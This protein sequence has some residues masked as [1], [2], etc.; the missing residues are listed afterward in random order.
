MAKGGAA[1]VFFDIVGTFQ[2]ERI[3]GD[4]RQAMV[5]KQAIIVD[6][7]GGI[8]DA[9]DE[10]FM[11]IMTATTTAVESFKLYED[12]LIRVRKFY[13]GS[14]EEIDAF[15][16]S[17]RNLGEQF[18]FTGAEALSA[19]ARTAQLKGVLKSQNAIIEATRAGLLLAAV[20]EME[21][22]LAMN[23]FINLAQQT[24]FLM[25]NMTRAQYDQLTAEQQANVIRG[26]SIR[27]LD[28]LNTIEN[29]SVAVME[30]ITFVLNQFA[31]QANIAGES[32]GEMA[33][34]SALLLETGEEVSRAGTGLRM[35]YQRVGNVNT[36]AAK[37]I[38]ALLDGVDEQGVAQMRLTDI[39]KE[40]TPAYQD[41]TAEQKRNLAVAV[42]GVRHYVK[43]LKLMENTERLTELQ[44]AAYHGQYGAIDEFG[45]RS[46]SMSFKIQATEARIENLRVAIGD[47]LAPAYE[48]GLQEQEAFFNSL[49]V[50]MG[51]KEDLSIVG[52]MAETLVTA[53]AR[54][55]MIFKPI[56]SAG[57][58]VI[59]LVISFKTLNAILAANSAEVRA[60]SGRFHEIAANMAFAKRHTG[61]FT[62]SYN[63]GM[64]EVN[65]H[66]LTAHSTISKYAIEVA[67]LSRKKL[68]LTRKIATTRVE[69][70]RLRL[71]SLSTNV[72][73]ADFPSEPTGQKMLT[74]G[75][76][77]VIA[78][79]K[80][81]EYGVTMKTVKRNL[82]EMQMA[83]SSLETVLL[84]ANNNQGR[85][86]VILD[87]GTQGLIERHTA[88]QQYAADLARESAMIQEE[89]L[90]L[91]P[92]TAAEKANLTTKVQANI[93]RINE[94]RLI[95]GTTIAQKAKTIGTKHEN[96][97]HDELILSL[98]EKI[99]TE[100]EDLN[101]T[102]QLIFASEQTEQAIREQ[103]DA[104]RIAN[105]TK[106]EKFKAN[107]LLI[108]SEMSLAV[109]SRAAFKGLTMLSMILP[110]IADAEDQAAAMAFSMSVMMV[111]MLIP[112]IRSGSFALKEF[113]ISLGMATGGITILTALIGYGAF[114]MFTKDTEEAEDAV[115][116]LNQSMMTTESLL[117]SI[118]ARDE[119]IME[120]VLGDLTY[121]DLKN[122]TDLMNTSLEQL[123][124]RWQDLELAKASATT[125]AFRQDMQA[126]QD[127]I[128]AAVISV[129]ALIDGYKELEG[130]HAG[131][132]EVGI[133]EDLERT[134]FG[135]WKNLWG[136]GDPKGMTLATDKWFVE[137]TDM[138][139]EFH[140]EVF[141]SADEAN[142]RMLVLQ[143]D[144]EQS[145][146]DLKEDFLRISLGL[147][148]EANQAIVASES[149][150]QEQLL[151]DMNKFNS[152]RE[153]LF[154]GSRQNFTGT[155]MRQVVQGGIENLLHKVEVFQTNNFNGMTLPEMVE[156]VS[157]GVIASI[158]SS[159]S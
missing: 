106:Y 144:H 46:E 34:M 99:A 147:T 136:L 110:M 31:S 108:K 43:F 143:K 156:A 104:Q 71:A 11:Q 96:A 146:L 1:R 88:S 24:H 127:A 92:L 81:F 41:M 25:G 61:A 66:T 91:T 124:Q 135:T 111:T 73:L 105:M 10:M 97:A 101:M 51:D 158:N 30:D 55:Q 98:D 103:A 19:S 137:W 50:A 86:N 18:A 125:D 58:S 128:A 62:I 114:K 83:H 59:N 32:I 65:L 36:N 2:A 67:N 27:V 102:R 72:T 54:Y 122:N 155:L 157:E 154:F 129:T 60:S 141:Y 94:L 33:A 121:E 130:I 6:A 87:T 93:E 80:L 37:A 74:L 42:G 123:N 142:A 48:K 23:R 9:F 119:P 150:V 7:I 69:F 56:M 39:I 100:I 14:Q 107:M 151:N 77:T 16:D 21:T 149:S 126:E 12:Q 148:D 17:S 131:R 159:N 28:Q 70:N 4:T 20:G 15:A 40:I 153:E 95:R 45:N 53:G 57:M 132:F 152:A 120:S 134:E 89:L 8:N 38:A 115:N 78:E 26:N 79:Q 5:V 116:G 145:S 63:H 133:R 47:K 13:Q 90:I 49:N 22:E 138:Q 52:K 35:I 82:L 117:S 64:K 139:G 44:T 113:S 85:F 84:N 29:S 118:S 68:D 3:L 140:S 112:S 76:R 75:E 109:A